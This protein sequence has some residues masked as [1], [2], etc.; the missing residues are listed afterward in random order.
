MVEFDLEDWEKAFHVSHLGA[1][2][3]IDI[4]MAKKHY[5]LIFSFYFIFFGSVDKQ[6]TH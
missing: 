2:D 3:D 1:L 5:S 6:C 4:D